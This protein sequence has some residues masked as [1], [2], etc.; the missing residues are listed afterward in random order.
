MIVF[1]PLRSYAGILLDGMV[2]PKGDVRTP[3]AG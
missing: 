3:L 2:R 1:D